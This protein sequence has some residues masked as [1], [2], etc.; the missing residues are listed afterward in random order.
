MC[1]KNN[2]YVIE[3]VSHTLYDPDEL[4]S[5]NFGSPPNTFDKLKSLCLRLGEPGE[6]VLTPDLN[7][8]SSQLL[9]TDDI[10][11]ER[12]HKV[13][14]LDYFNMK[15]E[16]KEQEFEKFIG[17]ETKVSYIISNYFVFLYVFKNIS[18]FRR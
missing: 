14:N 8:Y 13:Q 10:Y 18:H 16:C 11:V 5:L 3:R 7:F 2:V 4:C 15:P 12:L 1:R 17:G 9:N 6:P